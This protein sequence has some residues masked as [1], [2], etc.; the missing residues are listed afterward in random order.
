MNACPNGKLT[1]GGRCTCSDCNGTLRGNKF[2]KTRSLLRRHT[3]RCFMHG[4][5][6]EH[7]SCLTWMVC[8]IC[9]VFQGW[10]VGTLGNTHSGC[11]T[12]YPRVGTSQPLVLSTLLTLFA[13]LCSCSAFTAVWC[14]ISFVKTHLL[15]SPDPILAMA[16]MDY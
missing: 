10:D 2:I 7:V 3:P 5:I 8:M 6:V 12:Q 1:R 13:W 14:R 11:I 4:V 16:S 9:I 15:S